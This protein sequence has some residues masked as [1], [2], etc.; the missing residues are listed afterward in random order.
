MANLL[1]IDD[2]A[3]MLTSLSDI[4]SQAGHEV[5]SVSSGQEAIAIAATSAL[6][7]VISDIRMAGLDGIQTIEK[8]TEA[9]PELKS[10]VITGYASEDTPGRAMDVATCDYLCKPFTAE[11]LLQSVMRA[12][13]VAEEPTPS[14]PA[15]MLEN[16]VALTDLQAARMRAFQNFYLGIRS[17]HLGASAALAI[18]DY[19]EGVELR[20]YE[21]DKSLQLRLEATELQ[22]SYVTASELCKS[23]KAALSSLKRKEGGVSRIAFQQFY[24]NVRDGKI[25][26][27]QLRSAILLR[28]KVQNEPEPSEDE[29]LRFA[30][31]WS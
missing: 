4:L 7:L 9:R 21:A 22:D 25:A 27:D 1:I 20:H 11:Q 15:E 18:W 14:Y 6:D 12:L 24:N 26:A 31:L 17:S 19:L 3:H 10:I 8:L 16:M 28:Q 5:A 13:A 2:D 30:A 23:G 29:Q